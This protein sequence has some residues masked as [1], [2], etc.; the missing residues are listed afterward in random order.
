MAKCRPTQNGSPAFTSDTSDTS[1]ARMFSDAKGDDCAS[2]GP[3][4]RSA[5]RNARKRAMVTAVS[6]P[7]GTFWQAK[8]DHKRDH[9]L[10]S[11]GA[12]IG[13]LAMTP[14]LSDRHL[15][16]T[17]AELAHIGA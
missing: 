16:D 1:S 4:T 15:L 17:L 11:S 14:K 9:P 12:V 13:C 7:A 2:A 10:V 6:D 3:A 5:S 8:P